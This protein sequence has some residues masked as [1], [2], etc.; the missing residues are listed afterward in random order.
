M[1]ARLAALCLAG[2]AAGYG[3]A[4]LAGNRSAQPGQTAGVPFCLLVGWSFIGC[5]LIAWRQRPGNRL[6]PVMIFIG[7]AWFAAFLTDAHDALLFTV[8][9]AV[10]SVYLVGFVYLSSRS[11]RAA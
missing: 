8:G 7:F 6:G 5:G 4:W 9:T 10:Q 11:R 1:K 2:L 3:A